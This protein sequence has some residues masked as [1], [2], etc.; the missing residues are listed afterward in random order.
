MYAEKHLSET[1]REFDLT[2]IFEFLVHIRTQVR[3]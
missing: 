2:A 1:S 3:I